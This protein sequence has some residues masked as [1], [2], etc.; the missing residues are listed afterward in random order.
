[1]LIENNR[2]ISAVSQLRSAY[3]NAS[4]FGGVGGGVRLLLEYLLQQLHHGIG[5][6]ALLEMLNLD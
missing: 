2:V 6:M 4:F 3:L 5:A 1:M